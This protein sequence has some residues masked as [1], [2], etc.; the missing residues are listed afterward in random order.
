[1]STIRQQII[2]LLSEEELNAREISQAIS[3]MEREVYD[4]LQHIDR[5]LSRVGKKLEVTPYKCLKCG[6]LFENRKRWD[7]PGRC[8]VCKK[9]HISMACF[10]VVP[11]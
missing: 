11:D 3:I 6:Y 1:M 7:R 8:P 9:G 10:R 5:S 2:D 4:H